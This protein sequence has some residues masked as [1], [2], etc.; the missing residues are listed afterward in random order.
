MPLRTVPPLTMS[1]SRMTGGSG[2][3]VMATS[4]EARGSLQ[5]FAAT[6]GQGEI[7]EIERERLEAARDD[8]A[9]ARL[10]CNAVHLPDLVGQPVDLAAD[11]DLIRAGGGTDVVDVTT[12]AGVGSDD[13]G[14][15]ARPSDDP[16]DCTTIRHIEL[17]HRHLCCAR[18][19]ERGAAPVDIAT[20]DRPRH[21][22]VRTAP[23][24]VANHLP[25]GGPGGTE[26]DDVVL[27]PVRH[28]RLEMV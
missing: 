27:G 3:T 10:P 18:G 9:A 28:E 16:L 24:Q 4:V 8:D 12:E 25:S 6:A 5:T 13:V 21:A 19:D 20:R 23:G 1:C 7:D 15:H 11:I 22:G 14:D 17:E 26:N 2:F